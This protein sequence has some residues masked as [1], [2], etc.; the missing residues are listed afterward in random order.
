MTDRQRISVLIDAVRAEAGGWTTA[1]VLRTWKARGVD[2]PQRHTARH[3]LEHL[4]R[5]GLLRRDDRD[6]D[7]REYYPKEAT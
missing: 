2:A 1:R 5:R 3:A 7:R 6:P 4:A